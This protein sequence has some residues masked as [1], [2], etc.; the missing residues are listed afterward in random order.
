MSRYP[1]YKSRSGRLGIGAEESIAASGLAAGEVECWS[2]RG[3]SES[4]GNGTYTANITMA[5]SLNRAGL[6]CPSRAME[7]AV[8]CCFSAN[9]RHYANRS[10]K[11]STAR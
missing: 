1:Y 6:M 11:W 2:K 10:N 8:I 9:G 4:E 7:T 5:V 3:G